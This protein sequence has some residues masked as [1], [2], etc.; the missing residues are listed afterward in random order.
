MGISFASSRSA[1][2]PSS[3][4]HVNGG[5][6]ARRPKPMAAAWR[7][8]HGR[9]GCWWWLCRD[10]MSCTI[11]LGEFQ[12]V[13][14]RMAANDVADDHYVFGN[15]AG[16][17]AAEQVAVAVGHYLPTGGGRSRW[18]GCPRCLFPASLAAARGN[19][20]INDE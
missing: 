16:S 12:Q 6:V 9:R 18:G 15:P 13:E 1:H 19:V 3:H 8:R 17:A 2:L 11:S 5:A 10:E 4:E 7:R 14:R 20:L